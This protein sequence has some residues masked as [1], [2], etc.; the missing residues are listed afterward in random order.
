MSI[1]T[2][3]TVPDSDIETLG[4][5]LGEA[6]RNLPE[7]EAFESAKSAVESDDELQEQIQQ[8]ESLRQ[9]FMLARQTGDASQDDLQELQQAQS[10]L[11][12]QPTMS[13]YLEAQQR[14]DA[15]LEAVNKAISEPLDVDFGE[16]AGG[17]CQD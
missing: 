10:E 13:E 9:E 7:Y 16:Q 11:H 6:I 8:F 17:C 4:R 1:D 14:L 5:E 3:V 2:E 15:R 12:S